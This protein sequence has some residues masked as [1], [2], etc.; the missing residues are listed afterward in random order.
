MKEAIVQGLKWNM[1]DAI[2]D[3]H[4]RPGSAEVGHN[5]IWEWHPVVKEELIAFRYVCESRKPRVFIDIGAHC[6]IFSSVY[7]TVVKDHNCHSIEPIAE[8]MT[9]LKDTADLNAWKLNVHPIALNNYVGDSYYHNTHMAM[10]TDSKDRVV[11]ELDNNNK[12]NNII[13]EVAVTT[14]DNFVKQYNLQ[15][16]LIKIDVEGYEVPVLEQ[17]IQTLQD[18]DVDLFIETHR[19]ECLKLGWN[20]E[21]SL[22]HI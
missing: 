17:A 19:D 1:N 14:L 12:D 10:F 13:H 22:I 9:R 2:Y 6:G 8:H 16:D 4:T 21:L 20:I 18:N 5:A 11:G 7:C 15:P 3:W